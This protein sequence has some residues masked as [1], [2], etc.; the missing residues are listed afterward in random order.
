[1]CGIAG[2]LIFDPSA[3][4]ERTDV[5]AM[6]HPI[7]HR[8]PDAQGVHL[9]GNVGLGHC[10]LSIIDLTTGAQP[11]ANEDETVWIIFNGE[12]Y[13]YRELRDQLLAKG[14][15]FRSKS[16]TEVIIHA[17]EEFGVDCVNELRGMF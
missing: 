11:M 9:D 12:I 15:L 14:H 13:N 16:D 10:R 6:L 8:G 3:C 5:Q 2:K 17:Y 1:M 7:T 4:V